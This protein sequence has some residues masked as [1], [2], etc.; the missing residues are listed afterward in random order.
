L[1]V[2]GRDGVVVTDNNFAVQAGE[3]FGAKG[4]VQGAHFIEEAP[5]GPDIAFA[6]IFATFPDLRAGVVGGAGLRGTHPMLHDLRDVEVA[7][8]DDPSH[9]EHIGA[10]DVPVNDVVLVECFEALEQLECHL[11]DEGLFQ[12][13]AVVEFEAIVDLGLQVT[14]VR[15][16]HHHTEGLLLWIK[17]GALISDDIRDVD[18]CQEPDFIECAVFLFLGKADH[19]D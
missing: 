10:F 18:G 14:T 2:A 16:L 7:Q 15:I 13:L 1:R 8:F 6:T 4:R 17:E 9:E 11:P 3:I 19:I 12:S 5:S